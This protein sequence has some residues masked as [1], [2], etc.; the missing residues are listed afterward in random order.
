M[1][2]FE[3]RNGLETVTVLERKVS[4]R[5]REAKLRGYVGNS[6]ISPHKPLS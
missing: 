1:M 4:S 6:E 5:E 3:K 2:L